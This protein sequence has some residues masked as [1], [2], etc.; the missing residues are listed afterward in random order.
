MTKPTIIC[1]IENYHGFFFAAFR[2]LEDNKVVTIEMSRRTAREDDDAKRARVRGILL[3]NTIITFNGNGYDIPLLWYF[4]SGAT[5]EE[6]KEASDRIINA[7]VR[8][9]QVEEVIGIRVPREIDHIDLIEP[10]PNPVISLKSLNGRL[11]G[12]RLQDLPLDPAAVPT[13]AEM[14]T[15]ADYCVNSDIPATE[16][17]L[18]ALVDPIAMRVAIGKEYDTDYRSKSDA[19]M[20]EAMI[21]RRVEQKLGERVQ[22]VKTPPGT[23]FKFPIPPYISFTHPDLVEMLQRLRETTFYVENDG[24]VELPGWLDGKQITIGES[25]YA[26]GIGGLHSTESNRSVYGDDDTVLVDV[27]VASYYPAIIINSGLYPK[28]LGPEFINVFR[29]IRAERVAA[30]AE[31]QRITA[32]EKQR[33]LTDDERQQRETA[34]AKEA[35]LKIALNGCFGKLGSPYSVL[36]APHLMIA[37]TLTGQLAL[38]MLIDRAEQKRISVVSA[39]TDGVVFRCPRDECSFPI[40]KTR[41]E[42]EGILRDLVE[43]WERDTEFTLE[44]TEYLS[45][46][47]SSV[48]SYIAVKPDGKTKVKGPLRTPRHES[49]PDMRAQLMKNPQAEIVSLA[50]QALITKGTPLYD[51]ITGSR[52]IRDF[53]TVVKVDGG[54]TWRGSYLGKTVRFYWAKNGDEILRAKGHWKTG[55]KGKVSKSDGCRPLMDLPPEFPTDIDYDRYVAEAEEVLMDIGY[56]RRP[57]VIKPIRV[58][59]HSAILWWALAA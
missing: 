56:V 10:Q 16:R 37:T 34:K 28:A 12:E 55:T 22:K 47:N 21:K 11:H 46:H 6:L 50:V 13:E 58:Y 59:K 18:N 26:M 7:R 44:A 48:N 54:S 51:T 49:P 14:D 57:P 27:D 53:V 8:S 42:G 20:G 29:A 33:P 5:N 45:L 38:L 41:F 17:L 3:Q 52:D 19:Q 36:Y 15:L 24:K 23:S 39:N 32:L 2:R 40:E 35:G 4:V 31:A 1:D 30:K 43:Q 25:T 9:W